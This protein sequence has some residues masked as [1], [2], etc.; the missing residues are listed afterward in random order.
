MGIDYGIDKVWTIEIEDLESL[1]AFVKQYGGCV[2]MRSER[3]VELLSEGITM[4]L[5]SI[6]IYDTYRE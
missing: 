4:S 3:T 2:I 5:P 6:Q 1:I